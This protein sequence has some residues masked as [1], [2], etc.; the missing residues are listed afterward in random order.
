[1]SKTKDFSHIEMMHPKLLVEK[2]PEDEERSPGG[3]YIPSQTAQQSV[4]RV[5]ILRANDGV[6]HPNGDRVECKVKEGDLVLISRFVIENLR[7]GDDSVGIAH[8]NEI[9][10]IDR[11]G[12]VDKKKSKAA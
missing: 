7:V 8:E 6:T 9:L 2:L 3:I 11:S 10:A 1:M 4:T 12:E 5:R